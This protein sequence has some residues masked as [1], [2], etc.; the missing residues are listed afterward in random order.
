M[1]NERAELEALRALKAARDSGNQR[2][3]LDALRSIKALRSQNK[4][5]DQAQPVKAEQPEQKETSLAEDI[6][7]GIESAGIIASNIIAE[8]IAGVAGI[9]AIVN[10][11]Q[12]KHPGQVVRDMRER[13]A[14]QPDADVLGGEASQQQLQSLGEGMQSVLEVGRTPAALIGGLV[15]LAVNQDIKSA[16]GTVERIKSGGVDIAL[17]E[18][19]LAATGSPELAAIAH[20]LPT[21][22]LE[23]LGVAHFKGAAR[24][25]DTVADAKKAANTAVDAMPQRQPFTAGGKAKQRIGELIDSGSADVSTARFSLPSASGEK[26]VF[27]KLGEKLKIGSP[28]VV[29]D[30]VATETIKQGFD[31]GVIAAVK[32]SSP[33]DQVKMLKMVDTMQRGKKNKLVAMKERPTDIVGDS[34]MNRVRVIQGANKSAGKELESVANSLKGEAVNSITAVDSFVDD[35]ADM[36]VNIGDDL[37]PNFVGSDI[38]GATAAENAINKVVKRMVGS[39]TPD[40][41]DVHRMKKFI[42]EQVTFGKSAEGLAGQSER[43][44]KN[45]RRNLDQVLD[46]NFPEYDRVNTAYSE[47]IGA[48]DSLQ[49]VAGRKMNLTGINAD[50]A[51]GQLMRRVMSN[52][53]SRVRLVDALD[54]VEGV[55]NKYISF[56]PKSI[57]GKMLLR[58]AG[59]K[60]KKGFT[61][62]LLS[63]VLFA[64]ELDSVFKPVA[65]TSF[66]GQID[67]AVQRGANAATPSGQSSLVVEAVGKTAEKLRGINEENAFKA[68]REL[69]KGNK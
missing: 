61:D 49:D 31:E 1:A 64:D 62:D 5:P 38:E 11:F 52:A 53:Q 42:D 50:K 40:A 44:L 47:T 41:H 25:P 30:K 56:A 27:G 69:L 60:S 46:S 55:A 48:L 8:P 36:G 58:D 68:I 29:A 59:A 12:D 15:D 16:A 51:T 21:A 63:Q 3:E 33:D 2:A 39:G 22:A 43:V 7:G 4:Q 17:G 18:A 20:T 54:E 45:L 10:P 26:G 9:G 57:D 35:L 66:Q 23:L 13:L 65:R 37:K 28:D 19:T 67:Q 32:A 14:I 6:A 24:I 34:L